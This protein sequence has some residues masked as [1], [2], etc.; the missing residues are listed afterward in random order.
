[1]ESLHLASTSGSP[2]F[3]IKTA[4]L[5]NIREGPVLWG[6]KQLV[7]PKAMHPRRNSH[8]KTE[9][10]MRNTFLFPNQH[11]EKREKEMW[12]LFWAVG[13]LE[14]H[15]PSK[16]L[17]RKNEQRQTLP[18]V[19]SKSKQVGQMVG[20]FL[21]HQRGSQIEK[22]AIQCLKGLQKEG[23]A[24]KTS[25]LNSWREASG[26]L[27]KSVLR[28]GVRWFAGYRDLLGE[29]TMNLNV[30]NVIGYYFKN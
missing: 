9:Q 5:L 13:W 18:C 3:F 6:M 16:T 30:H 27:L 14:T 25:I 7:I 20:G 8:C 26:V 1:M 23:M 12:S 28:I 10:I 15:H 29:S 24:G 21:P 19:Q 17:D 22:F 4:V 2:V 11:R